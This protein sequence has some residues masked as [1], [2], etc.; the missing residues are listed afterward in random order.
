MKRI[1]KLRESDLVNIVKRVINE[2][3]PNQWVMEIPAPSKWNSG[4]GGGFWEKDDTKLTFYEM[5][6]NSSKG[7]MLATYD[8]NEYPESN[9]L[10]KPTGKGRWRK[11]SSGNIITFW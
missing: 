9:K 3:D 6:P 1:V 4:Y 11:P 5:L 2:G 8:N 7:K 10:K